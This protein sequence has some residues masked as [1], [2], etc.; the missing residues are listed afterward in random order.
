VQFIN[1]TDRR[2]DCRILRR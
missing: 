1:T 2:P